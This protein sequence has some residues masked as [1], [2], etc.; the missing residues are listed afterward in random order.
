MKL[1]SLI[2]VGLLAFTSCTNQ[3]EGFSI[4]KFYP[5]APGCDGVKNQ[6]DQVSGNGY[7]DVAAGSAEFFIGVDILGAQNVVQQP[8][9]VGTVSLEQASRNKPIITQ[10]VVTY[11]LSKRVGGTPKP[12]VTNIS[13]PFNAS[14]E[15]MGGI[16]LISP[17]LA[18]Q[19]FDGLTPPAGPAP[20]AAIE[21]FVDVSC[22]VEFKGEFSATKTPFSTGVLTFP[23]RAY[24]SLPVTCTNGYQRFPIDQATNTVD[25]CNYAGMS[26]TQLVAPS[27][28]TCC[29]SVG[30][31]GC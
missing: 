29:P 23:I 15:I 31:L 18:T 5:M 24:R 6:K 28:P 11:R 25:F 17:E 20:S 9:T 10:Q 8:V 22:D 12:Y 1:K 30:A 4:V 16:Q 3:S 14:G 19:L 26:P 21:D 27:P 7:L 2:F 13:L